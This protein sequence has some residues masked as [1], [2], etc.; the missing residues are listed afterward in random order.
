LHSG[1]WYN[2]QWNKTN[3]DE[4]NSEL[5]GG[6]ARDHDGEG[7]FDETV[8]KSHPVTEGLPGKFEVTDELYH[9]AAMPGASPM[10]I[11]IEASG[12]D[13]KKYPSVWLVHYHD[14]R[15]VCIALGHSGYA[16]NSSEFQKLLV[17]AVNW[18]AH[19]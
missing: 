12:H 5:V 14:A 4:F 11:L 1:L 10:E 7:A 13:G 19:R 6:G 8:I 3:Y 2:W 17:N 16:H 9:V 15:I 18:T